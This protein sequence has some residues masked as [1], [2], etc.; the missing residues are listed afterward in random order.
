MPVCNNCNLAFEGIYR[1]H[2][3]QKA[4]V[5]RLSLHK[6]RYRVFVLIL[7]HFFTV[8]PG[9]KFANWLVCVLIGLS[10]YLLLVYIYKFTGLLKAVK[11]DFNCWHIIQQVFS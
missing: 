7:V 11:T 5:G 9:R 2:C 1:S 6:I 4:S 10:T 3:G 8:F